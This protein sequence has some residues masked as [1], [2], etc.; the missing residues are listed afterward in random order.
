MTCR[1]CGGDC[2]QPDFQLI[3]DMALHAAQSAIDTMMMT[4]DR[5]PRMVDKSVATMTAASLVI[6]QL[7]KMMENANKRA[8]SLR[9]LAEGI[10]SDVR[11]MVEAQDD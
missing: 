3:S 9:L 8:P 7:E 1:N 10:L 4:L 11:R 6:C 5:L 2:D